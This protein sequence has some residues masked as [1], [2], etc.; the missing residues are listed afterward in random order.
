MCVT[1]VCTSCIVE[2]IVLLVDK[3]LVKG[4]C[5]FGAEHSLFHWREIPKIENL[6]NTTHLKG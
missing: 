1:T 4:P 2:Q 5:K 6:K 3:C